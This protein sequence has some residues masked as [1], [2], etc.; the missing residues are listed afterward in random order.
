[1][2]EKSYWD[3]TKCRVRKIIGKFQY[4]NKDVNEEMLHSEEVKKKLY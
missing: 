2:C 4:T 3:S 1:M